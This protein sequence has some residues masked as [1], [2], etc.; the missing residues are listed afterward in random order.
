MKALVKTAFGQGNCHLLHW[1]EPPLAPTDVI[2]RVEWAGIC[3]TDIRVL[4]GTVEHTVPVVMGHEFAGTVVDVGEEVD[5]IS[6]GDRVVA[7]TSV[8]TCGVCEA[9]LAGYY[10]VCRQR[11]G[12]GRTAHGAFRERVNV[13]YR[14]VHRIPDEVSVRD[15]ALCEPAA[16]AHHAVSERACVRA[17]EVVYVFGPGPVGILVAQMSLN[18]GADVTV[19]GLEEDENRLKLCDELGCETIVLDS[20][21]GAAGWPETHAGLAG[22][23]VVFEC[24]GS[25]RALQS[26][27]EL[28]KPRGR[29]VQ[30]GLFGRNVETPMDKVSVSEIHIMG[31]YS[32]VGADYEA[33]LSLARM[34]KVHLSCLISEEFR[35]EDWQ[36]AFLLARDRASLKVLL[37]P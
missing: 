31:T 33:V 3:G 35:L 24:S 37:R 17:G 2:V 19:L 28:T 36:E 9:C 34:G 32:C 29:Y 13:H 26:A 5:S 12:M 7:E 11:L 10:N 18:A 23:D 25:I 1:D 22:A 30:V 27:L 20:Q 8:G 16:V 14:L 4:D 15:A 21:A 6:I